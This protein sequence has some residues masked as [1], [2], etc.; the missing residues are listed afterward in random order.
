L[1]LFKK[2]G[3]EKLHRDTIVY[4]PLRGEGHPGEIESK[5]KKSFKMPPEDATV[6]SK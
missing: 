5:E 2:E 1:H 6:P 3:E 4:I